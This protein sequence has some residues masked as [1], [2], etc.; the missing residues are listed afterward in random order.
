MIYN[1]E[2]A[3]NFFKWA[4]I[5][6]DGLIEVNYITKDQETTTDF[7][8]E[9]GDLIA[10]LDR[11]GND[12]LVCVGANPRATDDGVGHNGSSKDTDIHVWKN[13]YL[14]I[15]PIHK[16]GTVCTPEELDQCSRF[17]AE[18]R[19]L[20]VWPDVV[21]HSG[22]GQHIWI[23]FPRV[24]GQ[25]AVKEFRSKLQTYHNHLQI[26]TKDLREKYSCRID[27]TVSASRQTK[28]PGTKKPSAESRISVFPKAERVESK[29][30]RDFIFNLPAAEITTRTPRAGGIRGSGVSLEDIE[31]KYGFIR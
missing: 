11:V 27:H 17:V 29:V 2:Y 1:P 12:C 14:D 3:L 26:R 15:E 30:F 18:V 21:E 13:L 24:V 5:E 20:D 4:N 10:G 28:L 25:D 22:N 31:K 6:M 7:F 16:P 19:Q 23:A 9:P 8:S